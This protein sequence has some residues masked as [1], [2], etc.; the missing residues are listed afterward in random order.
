MLHL[1]AKRTVRAS[2]S[3][4]PAQT[5]NTN[6]DEG[7]ETV[8]RHPLRDLP[9]WLSSSRESAS[10]PKSV[11]GQAKYLYSL[12]ERPKLRRVPEDQGD[13][14]SVQKCTG[15]AIPRAEKNF[16]DLITA[17]HK[18]LSEGCDSRN[19]HRCAVVAQDLSTQW[20]QS[21]PCETKTS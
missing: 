9:E 12:P 20:I 10:D 19:N 18:V 15:A 2:P 5:K 7:D 4:E 11:V 17:D 1:S 14:G 6:K 13:K 8:R 3:R 16:S 21:Y